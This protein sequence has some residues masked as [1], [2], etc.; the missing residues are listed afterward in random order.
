[1][2]ILNQQIMSAYSGLVKMDAITEAVKSGECVLFLGSGVHYDSPEE[3]YPKEKRPL[4]GTELAEY[5]ADRCD[6][7]KHFPKESKQNLP[8]VAMCYQI[9]Q[10]RNKLVEEV[11]E[12]VQIG[13]FPS[14]AL[15]ALAELPFSVIITTNYDRL[16]ENALTNH[17]KTPLPVVYDPEGRGPTPNPKPTINMPVVFKMHG[18]I[19]QP[20]SIVITDEDYI[21][22]VLRMSGKGEGHPVPETV[23]Y[24]LMEWPTL[25]VG[26]SLLDYNL[27]LLFK[28]LRWK[29]DPANFPQNYSIDPYPDP[30]IFDVWGLKGGYVV[31]ITQ[32]VWTFVPELYKNITGKDM[33]KGK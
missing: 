30:L 5:L 25:F 9:D 15:E 12:N 23:R 31:F 18:D 11:R 27:R 17:G 16:L 2:P 21:Q 1:M 7:S 20:E 14:P 4:L 32:S 10:G 19:M 33:L 28:T 29:L 22:F 8:R 6:F 13:K 3:D 24:K 26:Y